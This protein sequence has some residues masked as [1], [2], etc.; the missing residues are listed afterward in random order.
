[1]YRQI[2]R[3]IERLALVVIRQYR[4]RAI[5][6]GSGDAARIV[7]AGNESSLPVTSVAV[8]VIR[9]T[10]EDANLASVLQPPQHAVI[11]NVAEEKITSIAKPYRPL[12]PPCPGIQAFHRGT[13]DPVLGETR[14]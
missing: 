7:F 4:D 11:G 13:N 5:G 12:G 6:F 14:I 2:V 9:R 1:M 10:A 8:A 3:R